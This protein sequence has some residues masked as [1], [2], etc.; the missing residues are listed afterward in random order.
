MRSFQWDEN[1]ETGIKEVDEQHL[2][3]VELV[4]KYGELTAKNNFSLDDAR[5]ALKELADYTSYHFFEEET[6]MRREG[7]S[8]VHFLEHQLSHRKFVSDLNELSQSMQLN[9]NDVS[10]RLLDFLVHWLVY[11]ILGS[12]KNMARQL[13]AIKQGALP[14]EAFENEERVHDEAVTLLLNSLKTLF[15]QVSERNKELI[16]L[17]QSLEEKGC[18]ADPRVVTSK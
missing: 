16:Q 15:E 12:D 10:R 1:F 2:Y 8:E 5:Q 13:E 14:R 3:L 11:H 17:N 18:R 4:N 6:L 7:I 9:S